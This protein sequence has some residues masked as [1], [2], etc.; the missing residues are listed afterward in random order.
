LAALTLI[1]SMHTNPH[2]RVVVGRGLS[3]STNGFGDV[4]SPGCYQLQ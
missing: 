4:C 3:L 2:Y 1:L